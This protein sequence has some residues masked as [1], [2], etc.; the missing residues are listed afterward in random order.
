MP[1]EVVALAHGEGVVNPVVAEYPGLKDV[2]RGQH[3]EA[4]D[5]RVLALGVKERAVRGVVGD[6][7]EPGH[8]KNRKNLNRYVDQRVGDEDE[9]NDHA[10]VDR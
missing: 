9:K 2:P 7:E 5:N 4:S 8:R 6:D 10:H 3:C 1:D